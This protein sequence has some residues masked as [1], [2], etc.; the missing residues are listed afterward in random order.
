MDRPPQYLSLSRWILPL[1]P[2]HQGESMPQRAGANRYLAR[3]ALLNAH[4]R[5]SG[6]L[7]D[8]LVTRL[9]SGTLYSGTDYTCANECNAVAGQALKNAQ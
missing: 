5:N 9:V 6:R 3:R 2:R 4:A 7:V 8:A 1:T